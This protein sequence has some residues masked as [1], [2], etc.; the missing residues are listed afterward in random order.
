MGTVGSGIKFFE[1]EHPDRR[2]SR[3]FRLSQELPELFSLPT[4]QA[5]ACQGNG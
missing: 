2:N 1:A 5:A 4:F 3:Q